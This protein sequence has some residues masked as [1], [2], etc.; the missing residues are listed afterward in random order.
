MSRLRRKYHQR[1]TV[2]RKLI[3]LFLMLALYMIF[4][5]PARSEFYVIR[6]KNGGSL[7]TPMYWSDGGLIYF[8]Y[9]GGTVGVEKQIIEKV[10]KYKGE[11]NFSVS[12][13]TPDTKETKGLPTLSSAAEKLPA[14]ADQK[15]EKNLSPQIPP[16]KIDLKA[17]QDKMAK[18]KADINKTLTRIRKADTSKDLIAK[19]AAT[20]DNRNI[21]A[22]M[23]KLTEELQE[24]N[25]GKLPA[26]WWEGVGREEPE[27]P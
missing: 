26:D 21:S 7:A 22:E 6:L 13:A 1:R 16:V 4:P 18:L 11:R 24:K 19:E 23:W 5:A 17:Y 3:F 10:E 27:I 25:N 12:S 20:A 8:F 9:V 14:E 15:A 2:M